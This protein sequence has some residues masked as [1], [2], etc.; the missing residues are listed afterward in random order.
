M[1]KLDNLFDD[2]FD[3][4][5]M[6][7]FIV[8]SHILYNEVFANNQQKMNE[9]ETGLLVLSQMSFTIFGSLFNLFLF[10]TLR[11]LPNLAAST[12]HVLLVNLSFCN[13]LIC[14]FIKPVTSIYVGYAFAKVSLLK[15]TNETNYDLLF[16]M[17]LM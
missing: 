7:G 17:R 3:N 10:I 8:E 14:T 11:D 13:I 16:R 6:E 4:S 15:K 2:I 9:R 1:S 12:Y 5:S